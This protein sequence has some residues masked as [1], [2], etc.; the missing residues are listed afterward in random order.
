MELTKQ[1]MEAIAPLILRYQKDIAALA[2]EQF[3]SNLT[4]K[5]LEFCHAFQNNKRITFKGGVGFGKTHALAVLVWWSLLAHD[6]VQ[7]TIFGPNEGQLK[8]G[9]WKEIEILYGRM[10]PIFQAMFVFNKTRVSRARLGA[11]CFAEFRLASKENTAAARGIHMKNNFVFVDEATGLADEVYTDALVNIGRDKG[12]KLCLISNPSSTGGYFWRTWNDEDMS[13]KWAKVHGSMQDKWDF[14]PDD[15][16]DAAIDYGGKDTRLY[17]IMVEGDFPDNN[18]DGLIPLGKINEAVNAVNVVPAP[19]MPI[20]WGV[21]VG[22]GR[23]RSTMVARHDTKVTAVYD[24][25]NLEIG[26]LSVAISDMYWDLSPRE[27]PAAICVD[28]NGVGSGVWSNLKE[29][30]LPSKAVNVGS[31]PTRK[32]DHY[33]RLRD[34]LWWETMEWIVNPD[35]PVS[36]PDHKELRRELV[37]PNYEILGNGRIKVESKESI[38][39]RYKASPDFA[40]ALCLTF[41]ISPS[42]YASAFEDS[43]R[44]RRDDDDDVS[45][46]H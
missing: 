37:L 34:Q 7:V 26:P 39:S 4:A 9:V 33:S 24:F 18:E 42:R 35:R 45:W 20:I 28:S 8:A 30:G 38:R 10:H 43:L 19:N 23:D 6:E 2:K 31:T 16:E 13:H 17:R 14:D 36:L 46:A 22:G 15:L 41:A 32:Q 5:Q 11:S 29:M 27:R 1:D 40:D 25:K 3:K 44:R 21:D 12:G